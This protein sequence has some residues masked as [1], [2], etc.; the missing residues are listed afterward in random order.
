MPLATASVVCNK[1]LRLGV[2][3]TTA[4]R[5]RFFNQ[6][7]VRVL[8]IATQT[9]LRRANGTAAADSATL[10]PVQAVFKGGSTVGMREYPGLRAAPDGLQTP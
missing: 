7:P 3:T 8:T 9:T 5:P 2:T 4:K 10:N 1:I 6:V